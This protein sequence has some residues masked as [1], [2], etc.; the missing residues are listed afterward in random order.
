V[1]AAATSALEEADVRPD[2]VTAMVPTNLRI[3]VLTTFAQ[4]RQIAAEKLF[5]GT[6]SD[7]SHVYS[8]D[9]IINLIESET[10][11]RKIRTERGPILAWCLALSHGA[12]SFSGNLLE[13]CEGPHRICVTDDV[14]TER[15]TRFSCWE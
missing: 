10:W 12:P 14:D 6:I 5:T 2:D 1:R 15:D 3:D 7:V 9:V 8:A 13:A 4:H 11:R